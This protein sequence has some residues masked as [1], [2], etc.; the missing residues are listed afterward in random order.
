[1]NVE[2]MQQH[3]KLIS[4]L[5]GGTSAF[6]KAGKEYLVQNPAETN[7]AYKNRLSQAVLYPAFKSTVFNLASKPFKKHVQ[8]RGEIPA[9]IDSL[10]PNIDLE[11]QNLTVFASNVL[12]S[13]MAYGITYVLCDYPTAENVRTRADEIA[14]GL[15]PY[16]VHIPKTSVVGISSKKIAGVE[17]L[18]EFR[19]RETIVVDNGDFTQSTVDQI[20]VLQPGV[21]QIWRQDDKTSDWKIFSEGTTTLGKVPVVAVYANRTGFY[22]GDPLFLELAH[23]NVKYYNSQSEQQNIVHVVRVPLLATIG[24]EQMYDETGTKVVASVQ[25]LTS[26]PV[27]GDMKWVEHSGAAVE[28]GRQYETDIKEEMTQAHAEMMTRR[29]TRATATEVDSDDDAQMSVLQS[30]A[31][32][33]Q[34][35]LEQMLQFFADWLNLPEGGMLEVYKEF[36]SSDV[37]QEV[38]AL[39][40]AYDAGV[41]SK[42]T[43]FECLQKLGFI[44]EGKTF[45][46]EME[47]IEISAPSFAGEN[48]LTLPSLRAIGA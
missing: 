29:V 15:R 41:V 30:V 28:A 11:G 46:E 27:G 23:M 26:L 40:Q 5:M 24:A 34:D 18:T 16:A 14:A 39:F 2:R 45:D 44:P 3:D 31:Q 43:V 6:R 47:L 17:T 12:E 10:L 42:R 35:A 38:A 20:R 48:V 33:L 21:W 36:S 4:D 9:A 7:E 8:P 25:S 13:A 19:Y 32:N 1:M 37:A 22:T